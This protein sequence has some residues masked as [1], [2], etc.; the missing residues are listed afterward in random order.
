MK[1]PYPPYARLF[2]LLS[3]DRTRNIVLR[4]GPSRQVACFLWNRKNDTFELGQ[5][6]KGKVY[7]H[8]SDISPDGKH[9][10]YLAMSA[11]NADTWTAVSRTPWFTALD[12][13]PWCGLFLN[14]F[15]YQLN[16]SGAQN[17]QRRNSGLND[18]K[19]T[20]RKDGVGR[21]HWGTLHL[22]R[23]LRD[24]WEHISSP[25]DTGDHLTRVSK[26]ISTKW[27]LVKCIGGGQR[28]NRSLDQ[29]KHELINRHDGTVI[30]FHHWEWA[31]LDEGK[32]VFAMHGCMHRAPISRQK[33]I[34]RSKRIH[35]FNGYKFEQRTMP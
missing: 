6:L 20:G 32:I 2:V 11:K 23:L 30:K 16:G 8:R 9:W 17:G 35:D 7:D 28:E 15:S 3:Q 10:I 22:R 12:Y 4:R 25:Y 19:S 27:T 33:G 5:W 14:N 21:M 1:S 26:H 31:D 13:Y 24:G 34:G 29:E 18:M